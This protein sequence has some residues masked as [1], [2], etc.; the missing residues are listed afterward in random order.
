MDFLDK[1]VLPQSAEHL[2]LLNYLLALI[3]FL[4]IP[5]ISILTGGLFISLF[6][7]KKGLDD[8]DGV[9]YKF[10]KDVIDIVTVNKSIGIILGILPSLT[11]VLLFVQI[12][13]TSKSPVLS[14]LA[15]SAFFNIIGIFLVYTYKYSLGFYTILSNI[16]SAKDDNYDE[17]KKYKEGNKRVNTKSGIYAIILLLIGTYL[18]TAGLSLAY[19]PNLWDVQ[20]ILNLFSW[21]IVVHYLQ[22]IAV[23]FTLTGAIVMFV[24]FYWEGGRKQENTLLTNFIRSKALKVTFIASLFIPILILVNLVSVPKTSFSSSTFTYIII[25]LILIFIAYQIL[26]AMTKEHSMQYSGALFFVILF[27]II[28]LI[29]KDQMMVANATQMQRAVMDAQFQK[30]LAD[31]RGTEGTAT[32][33]GLEIYQ[34]RCSSCHAFD[35]KVVGPPYNE[36]VPKYNGNVDKL[37]AFILNPTQNNPGYPPM[38]NPG[39]KPNEAKAVAKYLIENVKK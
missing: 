35:K 6:Y 38:P 4:Y 30:Y 8:C 14:L 33:S 19:M 5:F 1:L 28:S 7:K 34:V 39:L 13:H 22:F 37:S 20:L 36:T 24:H 26:Y 9:C 2:E 16:P 31:L 12:L 25:A 18:F 23:A 3:L 17:F 21:K 10:A 11:L 15:S 29:L 32:V 27:T